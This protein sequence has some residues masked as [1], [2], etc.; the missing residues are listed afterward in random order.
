[1][2]GSPIELFRLAGIPIRLDRSWFAIAVLV[3][4]SLA[5]G[6]FP[7]AQPGLAPAAYWAMGVA[8]ALG[9]FGS[10]VVHELFHAIVA[11]RHRIP[12]GGITLFIFGGVAEMEAEPETPRAEWRMAIAG[13][14]ASV[15]IAVA[16]FG[17]AELVSALAPLRGTAVRSVLRYLGAINGVLAAFNLLPAFPLDGGRLLRA[18]L[19]RRR[20]D[21]RWATRVAAAVGRGFGVALMVLG[22][23]RVI[24]GDLLGGVWSFL[25]GGFLGRAAAGSYQQLLVRRAL[26]GTPVSRFMTPDPVTVPPETTIEQ[27]VEGYMYKYHRGVLPVAADGRLLGC[28]SSDQVKAVP[29]EE[30]PGRRVADLMR[31]CAPENSVAPETDAMDALALMTRTRQPGLLVRRNGHLAGIVALR[32]LLDFFALKVE[33]EP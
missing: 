18:A 25:L 12:M 13:P 20:G 21:L 22:G 8:G 16:A 4:W 29:R 30:W 28:I 9:L 23:V 17:A 27:L 32:D 15:V 31:P 26:H 11:R 3:V 14:I 10:I 24:F 5:A 19:W 7:A 1:M 2:F 33:L 6:F